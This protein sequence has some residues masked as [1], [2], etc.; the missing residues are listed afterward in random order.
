M[1]KQ[2]SQRIHLEIQTHRKNP[3]GI[4]RSS[5]REDGKV[6]HKTYGR[7]TAMALEELRLIQAAFR[8][9]VIPV[10]S[11]DALQTH[12][13]KEYGGCA[14]LF[15]LAKDIGLDKLISS[16]KE[17][18]AECVMAMVVGRLLY[19]GSKLSLVNLW[20]DSAIWELSGIQGRP[21]VDKHCYDPMDQ[22]LNRQGR[23]QKK[24]AAKHLQGGEMVLYDITSTYLEG[25]YEGSDLAQY[26]YNRDKK[27]GKLQVVA[28]LVCNR[29]GCPVAVEVFKGNTKDDTT[30]MDKIR[31]L[32]ESYGLQR[33]I[34]VGD[35]GMITAANYEQIR[36]FGGVETITALGHR[37]IMELLESKHIEPELFDERHPMEVS[38]PQHGHRR[39]VLCRN[40]AT[41]AKET[42]SREALMAKTAEGL[43]RIAATA[44]RQCTNAETIG[45][46]MGKVFGQYGM[47]KFVRH[48]LVDIE[49]GQKKKPGKGLQWQWD[50]EAIE[51]EKATDGCYVVASDVPAQCMNT[52]QT[53][54]TY[55]SL[56]KVEQA[57]RNLKSASIEIRPVYHK[58]DERIR[59]HAF[60]CMLSYYLQWHLIQR[61]GSLFE[62]DGKNKNRRWSLAGVLERLKGLRRKNA[63]LGGVEFDHVDTPEEG[64]QQ[65][66]DLLGIKL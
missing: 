49:V 28:G 43:S 64:Q 32:R 55:K 15:K 44:S 50:Q 41:A 45:I 20:E 63:I 48:K 60:L 57:F 14:T 26:G 61:M 52:E 5:Y 18:W 58:T 19:Q 39:L 62:E 10:G 8:G 53:V 3:I 13:S 37:R 36:K 4:L 46:R 35:R 33:L 65:I 47:G 66:L 38:D 22:L 42:A 2:K 56:G 51:K 17:P 21:D 54:E 29:E 34:F 1:A 25:D 6:V 9:E 40:A 16:R 23:I 7:L 59:A 12:S 31:Q 24:L 27:K 11:P 30:V